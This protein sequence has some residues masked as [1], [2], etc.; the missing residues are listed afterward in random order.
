MDSN[1]AHL[2]IELD[3]LKF[4]FDGLGDACMSDDI[5]ADF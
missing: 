3:D 5:E 1:R 2:R 4:F